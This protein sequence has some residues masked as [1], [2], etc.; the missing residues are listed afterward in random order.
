[1]GGRQRRPDRR[2][3]WQERWLLQPSG[4]R[5][6]PRGPGKAPPG[7]GAHVRGTRPA[8]APP[9]P[10]PKTPA[11]CS[12]SRCPPQLLPEP[13]PAPHPHSELD[14]LRVWTRAGG[15]SRPTGRGALGR[16]ICDS[17]PNSVR[18]F[19]KVQ[20]LSFAL[21][22]ESWCFSK[23]LSIICQFSSLLPKVVPNFLSLSF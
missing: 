21:R 12:Q 9:P 13:L 14:S 3:R 8:G 22:F 10:E 1:M 23:N 16:K 4:C 19:R 15:Q 18:S 5:Q 7:D 2:S 11:C 20:T 17:R 6:K